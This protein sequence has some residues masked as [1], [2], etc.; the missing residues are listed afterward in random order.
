MD[1]FETTKQP[2]FVFCWISS[3]GW[4]Q[5][6]STKLNTTC[7]VLSH[8]Y[9]NTGFS[10]SMPHLDSDCAMQPYL[11][12][13]LCPCVEKK[14]KIVVRETKWRHVHLYRR[15]LSP[16]LLLHQVLCPSRPNIL[17]PLQ[18][19]KCCCGGRGDMKS[20]LVLL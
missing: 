17:L 20:I 13:R 7:D 18:G 16:W 3:S 6:L 11:R 9:N 14:K 2:V 5:P 8:L 19:F 10:F 12:N 4:P 15:I 1:I